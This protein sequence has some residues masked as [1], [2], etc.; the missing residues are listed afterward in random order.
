MDGIG[1]F[2]KKTM[3]VLDMVSVPLVPAYPYP[4]PTKIKT[5]GY[6]LID[7]KI[8]FLCLEIPEIIELS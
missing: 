6:R 2:V 4:F 8:I 5:T 3:G 1:F 7:D